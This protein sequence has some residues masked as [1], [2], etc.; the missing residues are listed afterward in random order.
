MASNKY[1]QKNVSVLL[2]TLNEKRIY[3]HLRYNPHDPVRGDIQTLFSENVLLPKGE[4]PLQD[5]RNQ[6]GYKMG[7]NRLIV[8]YHRHWNLRNYLFPRVLYEPVKGK[9]SDILAKLK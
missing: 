4:T 5:L 6:K 2:N 7:T 9:V 1:K 3:L 8:C